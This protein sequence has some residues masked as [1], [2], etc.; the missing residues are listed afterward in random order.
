MKKKNEVTF[1][2]KTAVFID[3]ANLERSLADL[4][5]KVPNIKKIPRGFKWQAFPK[6]YWR[7][8]YKKLCRYF[9]Q[10][11]KL[12]SISFYSAKFNTESHNQFLAFLKLNNYRL[13]TKQSKK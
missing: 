13:V 1:S 12:A 11:S 4:G 5:T 8:D 2:G 10:E 9:K 6:G 3:A 7:V